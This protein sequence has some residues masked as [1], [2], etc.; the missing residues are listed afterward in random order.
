MI[1]NN[2]NKLILMA[3]M[4]F[5]THSVFASGSPDNWDVDGM[6]G[7]IYAS[8]QLVQSTCFLA[9]ESTEQ[10]LDLGMVAMYTLDRPGVVTPPV[11]F[12]LVLDGCPEVNSATENPELF[13]GAL[14]LYSQPTVR[15]Q[16]TGESEP[17]DG[18][19]YKV[20]GDATGVA[21]RLEDPH[22]EQLYPG[23]LSRSYPLDPGHNVLNLKAQLWR[24]S[25]RFTPGEWQSVVNV[26]LEYE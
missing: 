25:E 18:R 23:M 3:S 26:G 22:G 16:I 14:S 6:N 15:L 2:I 20:H 1:E 9:P 8:G 13:R 24:T 21:L 10:D 7:T 17:T 12:R 19:L 4:L 5:L 11:T